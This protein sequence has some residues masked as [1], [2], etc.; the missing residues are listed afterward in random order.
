[1][2]SAA[3]L[4]NHLP[5]GIVTASPDLAEQISWVDEVCFG[6]EYSWGEREYRADIAAPGRR[7]ETAWCCGLLVAAAAARIEPED[8]IRVYLLA[9]EPG[10]RRL[11]YGQALLTEVLN[12]GETIGAADAIGEVAHGNVATARLLMTA[13]FQLDGYLP[14]RYGRGRG[15]H[16]FRAELN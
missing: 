5:I 12:W 4:E 3:T 16:L 7:Y 13:G 9:V 10:H 2:T 1:M 15:S 14:N 11:G 6:A 8:T